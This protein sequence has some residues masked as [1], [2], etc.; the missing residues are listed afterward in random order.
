M[1]LQDFTLRH[2]ILALGLIIT[3]F[4]LFVHLSVNVQLILLTIIL[5]VTGIPHGSLDYYLEEE[6]YLKH[7][8]KINRVL[9]LTKYLL[10][11]LLYAVLWFFFPN[12]SLLVFICITAYHFGEIDWVLKINTW[13]NSMLMFGYGLMMIL[14]IITIHIH[15]TARLIYIL[16]KGRFSMQQIIITGVDLTLYCEIGFVLIIMLILIIRKRINWTLADIS[17]FSMQTLLLYVICSMLPFYLSFTFYFGIWHSALSFD[18]IR[19]Q[20][21][22][23][24][25]IPGMEENDHKMPAFCRNCFCY[26]ILFL[27]LQI[28]IGFFSTTVITNLIIGVA[29]LTL[30]H[31]QVFSRTIRVVSTIQ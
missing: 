15:D 27:L 1:V 21:N 6:Q 10:Y 29:I 19:K 11:M 8:K 17:V 9:F 20:L 12:L 25:S 18:V 2:K 26:L 3:L 13:L 7:Q 22:F 23:T 24:N 16:V 30:P 4:C 14:F 31:L 28:F 5:L